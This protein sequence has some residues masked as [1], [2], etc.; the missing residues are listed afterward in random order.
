MKTPLP[1]YYQDR[2]LSDRPADLRLEAENYRR[3]KEARRDQADN[4]VLS[5]IFSWLWAEIRAL[6]ER[7][8]S[9]ARKGKSLAAHGSS[10]LDNPDPYKN[11][12]T[13]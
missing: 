6:A 11:C 8:M 10:Y 5:R 12:Q 4:T 9:F 2:L 3:A 1:W 7:S 13:C